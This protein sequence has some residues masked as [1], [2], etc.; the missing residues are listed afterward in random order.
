M[1]VPL[2]LTLLVPPKVANGTITEIYYIN[3]L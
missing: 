2:V 3:D 1:Y